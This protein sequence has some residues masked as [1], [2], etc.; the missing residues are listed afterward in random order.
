MKS[1][2]ALGYGPISASKLNSLVASGQVIETEKNG[3]LTYKRATAKKT[4]STKKSNTNKALASNLNMLPS[5]V[6]KKFGLG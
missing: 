6:K 3:V 2:T 4:T 5:S 1:V